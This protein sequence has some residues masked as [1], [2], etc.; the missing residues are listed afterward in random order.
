MHRVR[1]VASRLRLAVPA[2]AAGL[3]LGGCG[4]AAVPTDPPTSAPAATGPTS[5][6]PAQGQ[7]ATAVEWAGG[8]CNGLQPI[9]DRIGPPPAPDFGDVAGTRQAY[10]S[11]FDTT[12]QQADQALQQLD[13]AGPPPVTNG[14]RIAAQARD[15]LTA[16]RTDIDQA[17]LQL[18]RA[19]PSNLI[20]L[21]PAVASATDVVGS[22]ATSAQALGAIREDPEL[23]PALAQAPSCERLRTMG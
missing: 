16:M 12:G 20:S 11:Y 10:L 18:Q 13:S 9:V 2:L 21:V 6:D 8:L 14:D 19:D 23:G 17:R 15:R 7:K 1:T 5:T 3:L 4:T 22:L